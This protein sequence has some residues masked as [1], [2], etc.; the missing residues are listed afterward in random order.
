[1]ATFHNDNSRTGQTLDESKLT[2]GNVNSASFGKVF[3]LPVDG[4]VD[5]QPLYLSSVSIPGQGKHNVVYVVTEHD[6]VYAFD[7]DNGAQLWHVSVLGPGETTS[8]N[9]GCFQITPE[10]GITATP[11]ISRNIGPHGT[12]YVAATSKAGSTYYQRIHALDMTTGDEQFGGPATVKAK[13]PGN[14]DNSQNG[15][16]IFD[17]RQY[18]ER[19]GLT[20]LDGVIYT[21]WTSHCDARP[22]TGWVIGYNAKTLKRTSVINVTP[23]GNEGGIWQAGGGLSA[24]S[25]G[26]LY[27][28]DGNGSFDTNL[29][30]KGFPVLGNYGNAMIKLSTTD[31]KLAVADYFNMFNTVA[32]SNSDEDLGSGGVVLVPP[33]TDMN[34]KVRHLAV[35]AGK[36]AHIYIVN[37]KNMGKFDSHKNN[38]YQDI[39]AALPGGM[40]AMPAYYNGNMYFGPQGNRLMHFKFTDA[41]LSTTAVS[42]TSNSFA[43]PGTTPSISANGSSNGIV[44]TVEHTSTSVLHAYDANNLATELYNSNQA[45]NSRDHFGSSA[46]FGTPMIANGRVF[47]GTTNSVAVFG[48]LGQ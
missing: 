1:V 17:P 30:N 45:A 21:A 34:G 6:S 26:G 3:T 12:I 27:F 11:V 28:L 31:R 43:Y 13:Y 9:H 23:N 35:G 14:G 46:H 40:W 41:K 39:A 22:Y 19:T 44:W 48:L 2:L 20:L 42:K 25:S 32:E 18:A 38:I 4:V 24:D 16:V 36:D 33:M 47:V 7:A 37:R 5:A 29:D 15:F 8:D 10:I